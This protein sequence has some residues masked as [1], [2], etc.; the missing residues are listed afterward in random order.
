MYNHRYAVRGINQQ[1]EEFEHLKDKFVRTRLG[2]VGYCYDIY[3]TD[4]PI[5]DCKWYCHA[6]V[7]FGS[8]QGEYSLDREYLYVVENKVVKMFKATLDNGVLLEFM[9]DGVVERGDEL[10]YGEG[11]DDKGKVVDVRCWYQALDDEGNP[12]QFDV[13]PIPEGDSFWNDVEV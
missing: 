8:H 2:E 1:V 4:M 13:I 7:D 5:L 6:R 11:E 12:V 9:H 10:V 3:K